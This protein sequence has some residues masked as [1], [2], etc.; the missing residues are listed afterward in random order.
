MDSDLDGNGSGFAVSKIPVV[1]SW[2]LPADIAR[3]VTDTPVDHLKIIKV[4]G[5]SM[6]PKYLPGDRVMVDLQQ[7]MPSPPGEFVIWDG[8]NLVLKFAERV[9]NTD[10]AQIKL[11]SY[12]ELIETYTRVEG[13]A[14]IQGRVIGKW[15]W[16]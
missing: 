9:P 16:T 6:A 5:D 3:R 1:D 10:P 2:K 4:I 14:Y 15:L 7:K 13:E 12:H 11:S 8:D